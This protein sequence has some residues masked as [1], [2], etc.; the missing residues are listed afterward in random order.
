V[1]LGC[2]GTV[3]PDLD[4]LFGVIPAADI[5]RT[6]IGMQSTGAGGVCFAAVEGA[7]PPDPLG[8]LDRDAATD[9]LVRTDEFGFTW[10]TCRQ[11]AAEP[12]AV[13]LAALVAQLHG[14][15]TALA[16]AGLALRYISIGFA[17]P[18]AGDDRRLALI[19]LVERGTFYPFAPI[20]VPFRDNA[21]EIL[22]RAEVGGE[23]PIEPDLSR[24]FPTWTAPIP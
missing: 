13:D 11:S 18:A 19:H 17:S 12:S 5:L 24:W 6:A 21:L 20:R 2:A 10:V 23:L 1:L 16:D 22:V 14:L 7:P 3:K 9:V 15:A 4:V 8:L